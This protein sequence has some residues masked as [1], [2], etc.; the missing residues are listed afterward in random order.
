MLKIFSIFWIFFTSFIEFP[1]KKY[2]SEYNH[3]LE[4]SMLIKFPN[5]N[6]NINKIKYNKSRQP[7]N[8]LLIRL[9]SSLKEI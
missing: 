1:T 4:H 5:Q 6:V 2:T 7:Q 8:K 3:Y 9:N